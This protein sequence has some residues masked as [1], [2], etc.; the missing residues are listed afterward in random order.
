MKILPSCIVADFVYFFQ[1]FEAS[2]SDKMVKPN[3]TKKILV[4][5]ATEIESSGWEY[6]MKRVAVATKHGCTLLVSAHVWACKMQELL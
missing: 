3:K 6:N 5:M 4:L 2:I 1:K